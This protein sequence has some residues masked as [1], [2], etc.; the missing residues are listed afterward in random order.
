MTLPDTA[1]ATR[2]HG[3]LPTA[4]HAVYEYLTFRL[5]GV[6]YGIDILQVQE[7]RSYEVPTRIANAPAEWLGVLHLRGVMVP[8]LDARLKFNY[9]TAAY[10]GSTVVIVLNLQDTI[11]GVVV[12]AVSDVVHLEPGDI[13]PAPAIY[14][15]ME[16][17]YVTGLAQVGE[18]LLIL[19]DTGSFLGTS[20]PDADLPGSTVH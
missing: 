19:I 9:P 8:I 13:Q 15:P 11:V 2:P 17:C 14:T 20:L 4:P 16:A 1:Q 5:G 18:R 10:T 7:I 3:A 12:D 6:E